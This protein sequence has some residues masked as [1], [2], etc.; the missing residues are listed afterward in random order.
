MAPQRS[1][2]VVGTPSHDLRVLSGHP[3][4]AGFRRWLERERK[5]LAVFERREAGDSFR[6]ISERTGVP[7]SRRPDID[8]GTTRWVSEV[9]GCHGVL[10]GSAPRTRTVGAAP[11]G[12]ERVVSR[13]AP[14][15]T[16]VTAIAAR[17][18]EVVRLRR[19]GMTPE[20]DRIAEFVGVSTSTVHRDVAA[21][22]QQWHAAA[23]DDL[24]AWRSVM[25]ARY[26]RRMAEI[27]ERM[28]APNLSAGDLARLV[29]VWCRIDQLESRLLGTDAP[30][31]ARVMP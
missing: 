2:A 26:A 12:C 25:L 23:C 19:G 27:D 18:C 31:R 9:H 21:E 10:G 15:G 29:M 6:E 4:P 11:D 3:S 20:R 7:L 8:G 22:L 30:V 24:D 13:L 17:R 5:I 14:T 1:W 16:T 28:A